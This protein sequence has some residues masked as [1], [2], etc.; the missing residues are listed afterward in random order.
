MIINTENW[1]KVDPERIVVKQIVK[2]QEIYSST[3]YMYRPQAG[4]SVVLTATLT[5]ERS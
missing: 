5:G 1:M 4:I 2:K 3:I